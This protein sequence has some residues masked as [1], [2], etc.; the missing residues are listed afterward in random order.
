MSGVMNVPLYSGATLL[1][2]ERANPSVVGRA[3]QNF[4]AT[5]LFGVPT[6]YAALLNDKEA[7]RCDYSSLRACRTGAAPLPV[8]I[9]EAFDALAQKEV[10]VEGYGLTETSP[11][12]LANPIDCPKA[13]SIGIPLT[14]TDVKV[15]DIETG[16]EVPAH[17]EG[18]LLVRGP[19]IMKGYLNNPEAT[20]QAL[21]DG[22]FRTGDVVLMDDEGRFTMVD[23]IKDF[24][25]ASGFKVW[26]HEIE[27]VLYTYPGVKLAAVIGIPDD[28]RGET[29]KAYI[30]PT[31]AAKGSLK[32]EEVIMHCKKH[33][34]AYKVPR[35]IEFREELPLSPAGKIL[36]RF[37]KEENFSKE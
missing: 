28:Y 26:P 23:R 31:T 22:W 10:L 21:K 20:G 7:S 32:P 4:R 19:Q 30:V 37:L 5:R 16:E 15:V 2:M 8:S 17:K 29:V 13:G 25:N 27:E 24:I 33:L 3:V 18:E 35:I 36:R 6:L 11:L 14:D 34:S 1:V 12:C 9:K